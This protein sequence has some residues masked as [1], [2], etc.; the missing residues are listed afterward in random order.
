M[1]IFDRMLAR[2]GYLDRA[3]VSARE[4]QLAAN[5][6]RSLSIERRRGAARTQMALAM[7][8]FEAA[9]QDRLTQSWSTTD[10]HVNQDL[11]RALRPLRARARNLARNND[12]AVRFVTMART[13]VIGESGIALSVRKTRP[14]GSLDEED[15]TRIERAFAQWGAACDVTQQLT[16]IDAQL[17]VANHLAI[18]GEI[19]VRFVEG[20]D[21][22]PYGMQ[23]QFIDPALIDEEHNI[24]LANGARIRMGIEIDSA[25]RRLAYH[26][27]D[28]RMLDVNQ[29]GTAR[30]HR[31]TRIP[32]AQMLHLYIPEAVAQLRGIPWMRA[33]MTRMR[34]LSGFEESA[35]VAARVG[36][37]KMGFFETPEGDLAAVADEK[38]EDGTLTTEAEPG[39]FGQLPPGWKFSEFSP[40]YPHAAFGDFIKATLRGIASGLSVSYNSFANDLEG[41]NF[42]SMRGGLLE[43]REVWK[44]IQRYIADHFH[45]RVYSRWLRMSLLSGQLDPLKMSKLA[46]YDAATWQPR[47]WAWVD[48]SKDVDANKAAIHGLLKSRGDVIREQGRDPEDV[49]V[50]LE[51]EEERLAALIAA[52]RDATETAA[53]RPPPKEEAD[54]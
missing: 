37:S 9:Q 50:E 16:W 53:P 21:A 8:A 43:E 25:G 51:R 31:T 17:L 3:S 45:A 24:D 4:A 39:T 7:R 18:D 30:A 38:A 26:V 15:N 12:W 54:A 35:V 6:Q 28:E 36:A 47:R 23:L 44:L 34:H 13:N 22:G 32:A 14:D 10:T 49:W 52:R 29:L 33:A 20:S 11:V 5:A 27:G 2:L 48:P 42:S 1:G 46:E 40:D 41:V 19:F